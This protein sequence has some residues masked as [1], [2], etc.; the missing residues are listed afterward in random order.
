MFSKS[1]AMM[2]KMTGCPR[3]IRQKMSFPPEFAEECVL[4][5]LTFPMHVSDDYIQAIEL[6]PRTEECFEISNL[7]IE[8]DE[9]AAEILDM[10]AAACVRRIAKT[11]DGV[12]AAFKAWKDL[13]VD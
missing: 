7:T 10:D 3:W 9:T 1:S 4:G 13:L 5:G 8:A 6:P 11:K 12:K 2:Y